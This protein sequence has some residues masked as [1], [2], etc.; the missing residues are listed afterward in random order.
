VR[1]RGQEQAGTGAVAGRG[2]HRWGGMEAGATGAGTHG[3]TAGLARGHR[4]AGDHNRERQGD[5]LS[6]G[7]RAGVVGVNLS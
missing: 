4:Q 6:A 2:D 5:R 1:I 3:R 7:A